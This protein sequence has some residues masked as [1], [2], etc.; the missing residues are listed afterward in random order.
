MELCAFEKITEDYFS[1]DNKGY[2]CVPYLRI[3]FQSIRQET[4]AEGEG[5]W[6]C[7]TSEVCDSVPSALAVV[8]AD[9]WKC[10][11]TYLK[12]ML[13]YSWVVGRPQNVYREVKTIWMAKL[14]QL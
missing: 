3:Q 9:S 1:S 10:P 13:L 14:K 12:K 11:R 6:R 5:T 8:L 7:L 2:D 4:G